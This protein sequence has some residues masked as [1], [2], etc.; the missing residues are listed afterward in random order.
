MLL[1]YGTLDFPLHALHTCLTTG[2]AGLSFVLKHIVHN[3]DLDEVQDLIKILRTMPGTPLTAGQQL[4]TYKEMKT[5]FENLSNA[6][7]RMKA[8]QDELKHLATQKDDNVAQSQALT[9]AIEVEQSNQNKIHVG[10]TVTG[11]VLGAAADV[12]LVGVAEV[13]TWPILAG[14]NAVIKWGLSGIIP[15]MRKERQAAQTR[16]GQITEEMERIRAELQRGQVD[17]AELEK[18][19]SELGQLNDLIVG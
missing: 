5:S 7:K 8:L 17:Q 6:D 11:G 12:V 14:T 18:A 4:R 1:R 13:V 9:R 19:R 3:M 2:Q 15:G 10:V 16:E